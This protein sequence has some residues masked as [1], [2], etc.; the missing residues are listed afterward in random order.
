LFS[1]KGLYLS[2]RHSIG[3]AVENGQRSI[4]QKQNW[5]QQEALEASKYTPPTQHSH[6]F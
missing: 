5:E 4:N 3:A 1:E 2:G 6:T